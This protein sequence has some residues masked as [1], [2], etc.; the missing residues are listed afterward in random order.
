M[1]GER[2][3]DIDLLSRVS[4]PQVV[5]E[6]CFIEVHQRTW[7]RGGGVSVCVCVCVCVCVSVCEC[8]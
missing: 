2:E 7:N 3:T 8:V 6:S 5:K 1:C 4:L